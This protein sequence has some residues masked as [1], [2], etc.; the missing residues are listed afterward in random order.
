M[1]ASLVYFSVRIKIWTCQPTT[2][3]GWSWRCFS[4]VVVHGI[5]GSHDGYIH[6]HHPL[7]YSISSVPLK[8]L[9]FL[10]LLFIP[11]TAP[12]TPDVKLNVWWPVVLMWLPAIQHSTF[13]FPGHYLLSL[14]SCFTNMPVIFSFMGFGPLRDSFLFRNYLYPQVLFW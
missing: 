2:S 4:K 3:K 9:Y 11:I 1:D 12:I 13:K 14:L 10:F 6:H 7:I 8:I 5:R